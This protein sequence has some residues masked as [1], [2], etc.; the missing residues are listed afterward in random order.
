MANEAE[1]SKCGKV[2]GK[3]RDEKPRR[4]GE[5]G[6]PVSVVHKD[7]YHR[8]NFMYQANILLDDLGSQSTR[9]IRKGKERAVDQAASATSRASPPGIRDLDCSQLAR[10]SMKSSFKTIAV[11]QTLRL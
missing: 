9:R 7:V 11:H 8:L 5:N 6:F 3:K 2:Q 10:H 1:G 4:G